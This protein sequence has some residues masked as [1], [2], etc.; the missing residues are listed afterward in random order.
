MSTQTLTGR[1]R[2]LFTNYGSKVMYEAACY[3]T[4]GQRLMVT[5]VLTSGNIKANPNLLLKPSSGDCKLLI[6]SRT[7]KQL[8]LEILPVQNP[9]G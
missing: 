5:P 6:D 7:A 4:V 1:E 9:L 2:M 3:E 8:N